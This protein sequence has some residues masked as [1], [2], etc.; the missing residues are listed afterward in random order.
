MV[1]AVARA[2]LFLRRFCAV[3]VAALRPATPQRY[4]QRHARA[5]ACSPLSYA[6]ACAPL[7]LLY[8]CV[9]PDALSEVLVCVGARAGTALPRGVVALSCL[10]ASLATLYWWRV[11]SLPRACVLPFALHSGSDVHGAPTVC[12]RLS[13]ALLCPAPPLLF[14][15]NA[16]PSLRLRPTPRTEMVENT[17]V[18]DSSIYVK[19]WDERDS[20]MYNIKPKQDDWMV[21]DGKVNHDAIAAFVVKKIGKENAAFVQH[22]HALVRS[23]T[24]PNVSSTAGDFYYDYKSFPEFTKKNHTYPSTEWIEYVD[25]KEKELDV[26]K[27]PPIAVATKRE[28]VAMLVYYTTCRTYILPKGIKLLSE[29]D[30]KL[31]MGGPFSW[32]IKHDILH[33]ADKNGEEHELKLEMK[34]EDVTFDKYP[35]H[36]KFMSYNREPASKRSRKEARAK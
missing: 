17:S 33:Y 35:D 8:R 10:R 9:L 5:A 13:P 34:E 18:Y 20:D 25:E 1:C 3:A 30:N 19:Y 16:T 26:K 21:G 11:L 6:L 32:D 23:K 31:S 14:R 28:C 29:K 22:I 36:V 15:Y 24:N 7:F 12:W 27:D 4:A 2:R